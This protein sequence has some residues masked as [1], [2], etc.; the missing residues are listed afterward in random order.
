MSDPRVTRIV[1]AALL[2]AR[3]PLSLRRLGA[4]FPASERPDNATLK[5]ALATLEKECA[6]RACQISEVGS[7]W[8][9]QVR[10]EYGEW[11]ERLWEERPP[12][13]SRA[14]L[15]TLALIAYRQPLTRGDIERVR[16]VSISPTIMKTLQ[17]RRWIRVVGHK[18]TPG[19]PA[20]Y[21]TTPEFLDYFDLKDLQELPSLEELKQRLEPEVAE[22]LL[23]MGLEDGFGVPDEAEGENVEDD[24]EGGDVDAENDVDTTI[25]A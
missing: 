15:E 20:L 3:E 7:G 14:L 10:G 16:G 4:L 22:E 5:A 18:E 8:R 1:E 24:V 17:E 2:A 19:R 11:V 21:G 9:L 25:S 12:R 6:D 13:Y 23:S